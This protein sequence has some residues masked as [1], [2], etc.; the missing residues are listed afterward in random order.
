MMIPEMTATAKGTPEKNLAT[1][2]YAQLVLEIQQRSA[3]LGTDAIT[4]AEIE[5]EITAV[6][7][8]RRQQDRPPR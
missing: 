1:T 8:A 5:A 7:R 3:Q 2:R 6:R 4:P